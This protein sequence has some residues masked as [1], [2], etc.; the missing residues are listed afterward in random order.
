[1]KK[2][3]CYLLAFVMVLSCAPISIF[4]EETETKKSSFFV[5]GAVANGVVDNGETLSKAKVLIELGV[6]KS[7]SADADATKSIVSKALN[8]ITGLNVLSDKFFGEN[9]KDS[10][11]TVLQAASVMVDL[12]GH[13]SYLKAKLGDYTETNLFG[14]A[15]KIGVLKGVSAKA[16]DNLLMCDFVNMVYNTLFN[17]EMMDIVGWTGVT[18]YQLREDVTAAYRYMGIVTVEGVVY[19]QGTLNL[20]TEGTLKDDAI[21]IENKVYTYKEFADPETIV[22]RYVKAY[23][24]SDSDNQVKALRIIE[25]KNEVLTL[26]SDDIELADVKEREIPYYNKNDKKETAKLATN[27][28]V[29]YNGELV[30]FYDAEDLKV[31]DAYFTLID[32]NDDEVYEAVIINKYTSV[33]VWR[34][35]NG[36]NSYTVH[37]FDN[38]AYVLDDFFEEGYPFIDSD[39]KA[40]VWKEVGQY[41][42][43]S[44]RQTKTGV[45]N[46][47]V[48][49]FKKV[50]GLFKKS[51]EDMKYVTIEDA[52]YKT[53]KEFKD[54]SL[55]L[56]NDGI[57][58]DYNF[59][60]G[61]KSTVFSA[62]SFYPM[63]CKAATEEGAKALVKN[64]SR[65]E[66]K[67]GILTC[68]KRQTKTA[69]QW[70]YPNG[71]ACIQYMVV[72]GLC[73]YGY[74]EDAKRIAKKYVSLAESVFLKTNNFWEKYNVVEGNI[75]V[76]NEYDMP[77]MMGWSA[78]VY[79]A[80]KSYLNSEEL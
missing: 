77:P 39:G 74:F 49:S 15:K 17:V 5:D 8:K 19:G 72:K 10:Q 26:E 21:R 42:V 25:Q 38:A 55:M 32:N 1:M 68:E 51:R 18:E 61:K 30:P 53:T 16:D 7:Y 50:N 28:N 33:I 57:Y 43:L 31:D 80:L 76:S 40:A 36:T 24:D 34:V 45:Y 56:S 4:A 22:G 63:F 66:A 37:G 65:L 54:N 3:I 6:L 23:M 41:D 27:V 11:L 67:F 64:L 12:A 48:H 60:S 2:I 73:N 35:S 13:T 44:I 47:I 46:K 69:Y 14:Y 79:L 9:F 29:V 75:N 52:E 58:L 78:G 71:W 62:A 70:D 59:K 20:T